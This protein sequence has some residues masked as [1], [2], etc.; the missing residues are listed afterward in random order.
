MRERFGNAVGLG[1]KET[2]FISVFAET[3]WF[4]THLRPGE[5]EDISGVSEFLQE[6]A[7]VEEEGW[8]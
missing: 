4:C 1:N 7:G 3:P 6:E 5:R 2:L 8:R